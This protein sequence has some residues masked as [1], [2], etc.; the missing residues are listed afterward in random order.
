MASSISRL[1]KRQT[2][3]S[4][5]IQAPHF[6]WKIDK[7]MAERG[8]KIFAANCNSCHG[9]EETD[10]RLY[11]PDEIGTDP[12]RAK[13]FTQLQADRFNKFL[14]EVDIAGY[15]ASK[16]TGLRSTQKY[17][18]A[19]MPG[20]WAR[21]PYLHNGSVRTMEELLTQPNERQKTFHRG[22]RVYDPEKMGFTDE[23]AYVFDTAGPGNANTGHDYGTAL[24]TEQKRDLMEYLKSL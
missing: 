19:S 14:A 18:A 4:E 11:S 13:L 24:A 10:K 17:W 3:I 8:A 1:V 5:Q 21:S 22:S 2:D 23:G 15:Q 9:G 16:M 6:P 20:V 7:T 12:Q